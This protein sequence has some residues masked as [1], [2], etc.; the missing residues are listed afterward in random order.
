MPTATG[1]YR[2][3]HDQFGIKSEGFSILNFSEFCD[4]NPIDQGKLLD[5]NAPLFIQLYMSQFLINYQRQ[6]SEIQL[7]DD[8]DQKRFLEMFNEVTNLFF[9]GANLDEYSHFISKLRKF[10]GLSTCE[11]KAIVTHIILFSSDENISGLESKNLVS[12]YDDFIRN[13]DKSCL[14]FPELFENLQKMVQFANTNI[15]W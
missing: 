9:H 3:L 5:R 15:A 1:I 8:K 6:T 14:T 4:L 7:T 13:N 2:P 11:K 12:I 10:S